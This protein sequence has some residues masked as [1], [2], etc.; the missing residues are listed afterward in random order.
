MFSPGVL[1]GSVDRTGKRGA[2]PGSRRFSH[3]PA[4]R[5]VEP[6]SFVGQF[7]QCGSPP[8]A[9]VVPLFVIPSVPGD[10]GADGADGVSDEKVSS[11][12]GS[13]FAPIGGGLKE[14]GC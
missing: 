14:L 2:I 13:G 7:R 8:S 11:K 3:F 9:G 12:E 10:D 4:T 5:A 6:T 1:S